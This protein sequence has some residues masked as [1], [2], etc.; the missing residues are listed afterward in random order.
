MFRSD[1]LLPTD[2]LEDEV[3]VATPECWTS[4]DIVAAS[5]KTLKFGPMV[6]PIGFRNPALLAKMACTLDSYAGGRLQLGVGAGWFRKEYKAFGY[7]F[8]SFEIRKRQFD[9]ALRIILPLVREGKVDFQGDYFS[10]HTE[11]LPRPARRIPVIIGA[12]AKSLVVIAAQRADEWN[13]FTE[14][15]NTYLTRKAMF[16]EASQGRRVTVSESGPFMIG[17]TVGEL[18]SNA[19]RQ[20][21]KFGQ[22]VRVGDF[23]KKLKSRGASCGTVDEFTECLNNKVDSGVKKFYFQT[24]TPENSRMNELLADTLKRIF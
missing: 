5:T 4:L 23:L 10:A 1:H 11:C 13:F 7:R 20:L 21:S 8:P 6:T 14:S 2:E 15:P 17:K 18:E 19:Q 16:E 22:R 9:E 12:R 3:G 24:I